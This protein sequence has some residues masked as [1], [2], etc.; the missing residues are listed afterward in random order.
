MATQ[1]L[2]FNNLDVVILCGGKCGSTTLEETIKSHYKIVRAHDNF[3]IRYILDTYKLTVKDTDLMP[4]DENLK[5]FDI[6]SRVKDKKMIVVF[7]VYRTPIERKIS[8]FFENIKYTIPNYQDLSV[9]SIINYFNMNNLIYTLEEYHPID[10]LMEYLNIPTFDKFNFEAKCNIIQEGN[11]VLIKLRFH[12]IGEEWN[13]ILSILFNDKI[14]VK[15]SNVTESKDYNRLYKEFKSK[16]RVPRKYLD[17][18]L[19]K[20]KQ[21]KIYNTPQEQEEYIRKWRALSRD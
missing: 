3:N 6:I 18:Y 21:F 5:L 13:R 14:V 2:L 15:D 9:D 1:K 8:S 4:G 20:D 19:S 16:Y 17:E 7:D 10:R 11:L 12:D